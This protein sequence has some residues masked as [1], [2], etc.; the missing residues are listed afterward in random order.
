[1]EF[2][3]HFAEAAPYNCSGATDSSYGAGGYGTCVDTSDSTSPQSSGSNPISSTTQPGAP[4]TGFLQQ[5]YD[6]GAFTILVPLL[7]AILLVAI[8]TVVMRKKHRTEKQ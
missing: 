6:S 4:N 1:M 5:A 8:S 2:I 7:I 3:G